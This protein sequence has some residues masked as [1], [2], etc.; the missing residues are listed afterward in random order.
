MK[1]LL[2]S[3][4]ILASVVLVL[5]LTACTSNEDKSAATDNTRR[6]LGVETK[7]GQS[8]TAKELCSEMKTDAN[9]QTTLD[10]IQF[11]KNSSFV[12]RTLLIDNQ[13][14]LVP[15]AT[16]KGYWGLF[17]D[18]ILFNQNGTQTRFSIKAI[19][20]SSGNTCFQIGNAP[21]IQTY[22]PCN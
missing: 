3:L 19:D 20:H 8:L 14:Q 13:I 22:C 18:S 21:E 15:Q 11:N 16:V 2:S 6:A 5:G 17:Q 4:T 12:K 9:G 7:T 10:A 1:V